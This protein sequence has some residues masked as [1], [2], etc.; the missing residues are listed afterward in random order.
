[1]GT[2]YL[3][4]IKSSLIQYINNCDSYWESSVA[5]KKAETKLEN[6]IK[7]L[8]NTIKTVNDFNQL[9]ALIKEYN[10]VEISVN[11]AQRSLNNLKISPEFITPI[12]E[13]STKRK[14]SLMKPIAEKPIADSFYYFN[15]IIEKGSARK[16]ELKNKIIFTY[17]VIKSSSSIKSNYVSDVTNNNKTCIKVNPYELINATNNL[18]NTINSTTNDIDLERVTSH[19]VA[20]SLNIN[21]F[22]I[23]SNIKKTVNEIIDD[24][25]NVSINILNYV[26][27]LTGK[28][29]SVDLVKPT[30][31]SKVKYS[32]GTNTK[33]KNI[34]STG[35]INNNPL[36]TST[37]NKN[38]DYNDSNTTEE[39]INVNVTHTVQKGDSLSDIAKKYYGDPN[40]Y[41]LIYE[42]NK[43][44]IGNNPNIINVG[45]ELVIPG[46][47]VA[48]N[49]VSQNQPEPAIELVTEQNKDNSTNKIN[50]ISKF[51]TSTNTNDN[52]DSNTTLQDRVIAGMKEKDAQNMAVPND[53]DTNFKSYTNYTAVTKKT[54]SNGNYVMKQS[55]ILYGDKPDP[56]GVKYNTYTDSDTH[57]RCVDINN[58]KYYCVAMG[59]YYGNVGD[60]FN[61]TTSDGNNFNVIVCDA[62]GK[63]STAYLDTASQK[64]IGHKQGNNNM[65]IIEFYYDGAA[66]IPD[67]MKVRGGSTGTYNSV[68]K[69]KGNISQVLKTSTYESHVSNNVL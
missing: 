47:T 32:F 15:E 64:V 17:G 42:A 29:V 40:K 1:M 7:K 27:I 38:N 6:D 18:T 41:N 35:I 67:A 19:Y 16:F 24:I 20:K 48:T 61:I 21:L 12:K 56:N 49:T 46:I 9:I 45:Q 23:A 10:E 37:E 52:N 51:N 44:I 57:V 58:E 26:N 30:L 54:D 8:D 39:N 62:K 68:P 13:A 5:S 34:S 14:K 33:T 3:E 66:G 69:F 60:T 65:S 11:S 25:N 53:I 28:I 63:D 22:D 2:N 31:N 4:T 55:A 59:D 50:T 43:T 36:N